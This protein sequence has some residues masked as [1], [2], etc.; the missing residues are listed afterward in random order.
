MSSKGTEESK[1]FRDKISTVNEEGKRVWVY[2][3]KPKGPFFDKRKLVSYGLLIFFFAAP[4]I[5]IDGQPLLMLNV[6]ERKFVIFF[7]AFYPQDFYIFA[8]LTITGIVS[9]ILFTVI[10]G[11]IFCGWICP[12]TIFMEMVFRRIEYWIEGDYKQ[13]KYLNKQPWNKEK[14]LKKSAKQTIFWGISF[15]ISNLFLVYLIGRD[16][17]IS[18]IT[19][20]PSEHVGGL[21][22]MLA[23]ATIFFFVFSKFREQVCTVVCPYGRLQGVLLDRKSIVVAYDHKRGEKR[24][25]FRKNEDRSSIGKGD[26]IDCNQCVDVCPTGIDIRNGTQLECVN[27]TA[28]IDACNHIMTSI[29]KPKGLIRYASEDEI[30]K[31]EKFK[32]TGRMK[33]YTAVLVL[34]LT[35]SATLIITRK[36]IDISVMRTRGTL[37]QKSDDGVYSNIYDVTLLNKTNND[38]KI[39]I[40]LLE[41]KGTVEWV[42]DVPTLDGGQEKQSKL[43]IRIDPEDVRA[44]L[45]VT[46]GIYSD[47]KEID[48]IRTKFIG[49]IL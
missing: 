44:E 40:K 43:I 10:Y 24:A 7:K 12:Q 49:P 23:F 9:V 35:L 14:I 26:C 16:A 6:V 42:G 2:P 4:F 30:E 36:D 37:Y 15:I 3:K 27:C 17:W 38:V 46:L 41:G 48:K 45:D 31:K 33:A 47:G 13:Q 19:D 34:M 28:C 8:L 5:Y 22:A 39:D 18:L 20:P 21:F 32:F 11:R 29:D 1:T 25:K